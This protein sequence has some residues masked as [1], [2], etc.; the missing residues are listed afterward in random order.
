MITLLKKSVRKLMLLIVLK[1]LWSVKR[2][3]FRHSSRKFEWW[4]MMSSIV[5]TVRNCAFSLRIYGSSTSIYM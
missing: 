2:H 4:T 5:F 1:R 3:Y